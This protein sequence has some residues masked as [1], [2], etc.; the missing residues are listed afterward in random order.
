MVYYTQT[1]APWIIADTEELSP[2]LFL[3]NFGGGASAYEWSKVYPAFAAE[4]RISPRFNRLGR[5]CSS[6]ARLRN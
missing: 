5:I 1:A 3:H 2:L 6:S 4:Y